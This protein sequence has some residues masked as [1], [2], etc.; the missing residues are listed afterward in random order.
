MADHVTR[1]GLLR[2]AGTGAAAVSLLAGAGTTAGQDAQ[3]SVTFEDQVTD[4]RE[5]V[6]AEITTSVDVS[7]AVR[8]PDLDEML[9]RG[10]FEAG[11]D[12][13]GVT[14]TLD[15]PLQQDARLA[16]SLY[17][18]DGGQSLAR[19]T[20][21]VTVS[22][23]VSYLDGVSVTR[24][25]A[26][27]ESGFNYPYFLYAPPVPEA[28]AGKPMLVEPNN[29]GTAT[30][31]FERH[32]ERARQLVSGGFSRDI[33]GQLG[34]PM[35][36][37]VFPRPQSD[38]VDGTH[39]VHQLDRDTMQLSDGPLERVDLQLLGMVDHAR[40]MLAEESYPVAEDII[41][42][43]FS[44]SSNF[45][46]RFT[47]LHP[48]R[49]VSVTAG[50]LNG[51]TLLPLAEAK[52]HTLDFH[53]G[54]ADV[55]DLT[56]EPVDLDA[57]DEVN[58]FLYM[59]GEDSNDTIPY[60]DAW[61]SDEL[62]ETALSV[63][64]DHMLND[65]FPYCQSAYEQAGVTAQFRVYEGVGHTPRPA[66]EDVVEFHRRSIEGEDVSKFGQQLGLRPAVEASASD[67]GAGEPVEFDA[68]G[69]TLTR[70]EILAY[71]WEFGDGE[72]AAGEVVTHSFEN[73]GDYEVRLTVVDSNGRIEEAAVEIT[74]GDGTADETEAAGTTRTDT[75]E[76]AE[77]TREET[78][79][80]DSTPTTGARETGQSD[81][82]G[83]DDS[84]ENGD[85]STG[86]PGFGVGTAL[87]SVGATTYLLGWRRGDRPE[88]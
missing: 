52:G 50:G 26:D 35:L 44:A 22:G 18:V 31:D 5:V 9:A 73:G 46:D 48:D 59:G 72:T 54:I 34:V 39:Y 25:D 14:I 41:M 80:A 11:T 49:V 86:L 61:T 7:Y 32:E 23:G 51:M 30:D 85:S 60:D 70:G 63:Y 29:T 81:E 76:D 56:G 40:Q 87:A 8:A 33:S 88:D 55:E 24:V 15:R 21:G 4:G 79:T 69:S 65:R 12:R 82:D 10:Q 6:I 77:T 75:A 38:P 68:T 83:S 20:A 71:T 57:L 84:T 53:V 66:K 47:V 1:R 28:E 58:Q 64:G 2:V 27:P 17:P 78:R 3:A 42:N 13:E 36:V 43:G 45:V 37:P 62:R 74:V 67:P 19:D 16:F